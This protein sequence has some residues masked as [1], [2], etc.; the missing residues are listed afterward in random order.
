MDNITMAT[1]ITDVGSIVTGSVSWIQS[2]ATAITGSPLLLFFTLF[3]FV[4]VGIG[5]VR[6]IIG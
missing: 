5:L 6:R 1:L 2:I 3:G 4:G